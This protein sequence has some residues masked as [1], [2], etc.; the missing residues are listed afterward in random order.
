MQELAREEI[1]N[2]ANEIQDL[3][4]EADLP[5]EELMARYGYTASA[6]TVTKADPEI[7]AEGPSLKA[8]EAEVTQATEEAVTVEPEDEQMDMATLNEGK[9]DNNGRFLPW[10]WPTD[11]C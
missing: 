3:A 1:D 7:K 8:S 6:D 11:V 9:P 4:D 2:T 10:T 5:L